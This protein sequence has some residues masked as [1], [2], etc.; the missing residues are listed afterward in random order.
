[1]AELSFGARVGRS[2]SKLQAINDAERFEL[3]ASPA[4]IKAKYA[5]KR[6]SLLAELDPAV[7]AAVEAAAKAAESTA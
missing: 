3:E 5:G 1:M 2:L 6:E 7:R 4:S